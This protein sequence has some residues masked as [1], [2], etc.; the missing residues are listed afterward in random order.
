MIK[1]G[2]TSNAEND[3]NP[4]TSTVKSKTTSK[5]LF[6]GK[7]S[8]SLVRP[9]RI[10]YPAHAETE[11]GPVNHDLAKQKLENLFTTTDEGRKDPLSLLT[12]PKKKLNLLKRLPNDEKYKGNKKFGMQPLYF[13]KGEVKLNSTGT[14]QMR[15]SKDSELG[16]N[17]STR[18]TTAQTQSIGER[19]GTRGRTRTQIIAEFFWSQNWNY[20]AQ[21]VIMVKNEREGMKNSVV[22][23]RRFKRGLKIFWKVYKEWIERVKIQREKQKRLEEEQK[24]KEIKL[25][26]LEE[27]KQLEDEQRLEEEKIQKKLQPDEVQHYVEVKKWEFMLNEDNDIPYST[28][29]SLPLCLVP[30]WNWENLGLWKKFQQ[31]ILCKKLYLWTYCELDLLILF[32]FPI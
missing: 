24:V 26:E 22:K 2:D 9:K 7:G 4:Y 13:A 27:Q 31:K 11:L 1:I 5:P 16:M 14:N 28:L 6:S 30:L 19:T 10:I 15:M 32:V 20:L 21:K 17:S 29:S 23:F 18:L 12:K 25:K 3:Q 8:S